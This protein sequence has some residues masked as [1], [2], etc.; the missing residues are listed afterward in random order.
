MSTVLNDQKY[1]PDDL[2]AMPD[3]ESFELVDGQLVER[4]MG[5]KSSRIG[6]ELFGRLKS[7]C[8]ANRLGWG[9]P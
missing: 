1:T 2:L 4:E 3:G 9:L 5:F 6:G 8:D 7:F